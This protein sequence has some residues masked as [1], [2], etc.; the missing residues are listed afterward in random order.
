MTRQAAGLALAVTLAVAATPAR[1][2][3]RHGALVGVTLGGGVALGSDELAF[4]WD[5]VCSAPVEST[6]SST[7]DYGDCQTGRFGP[8]L[9]LQLGGSVGG[10]THLL[11]DLEAALLPETD[12]SDT[13]ALFTLGPAVR[14][15]VTRRFWIQ[16]GVGIAVGMPSFDIDPW[17][18]PTGHLALGVLL[19]ERRRFALE[20]QTRV[21]ATALRQRDYDSVGSL[22]RATAQLGLTR[23]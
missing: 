15:T 10:R 12:R 19:F 5:H 17:A 13:S 20:L 8:T 6:A 2:A 9:G 18:G 22:V 4:H 14:I 3:E 7:A 21:S 1:A 23:Y 16:P 11:A